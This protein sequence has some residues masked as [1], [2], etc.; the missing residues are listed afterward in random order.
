MKQVQIRKYGS[1]EALEL[2][3]VNAPQPGPGEVL[4]NVEAIG[5]NYSDIL[6]RRNEY[7]LPT[8]LPYVLGTE[9][10]GEVVALGEGGKRTGRGG[11]RARA[12]GAAKRWRLR[13]V[14]RRSRALLHSAAAQHRFG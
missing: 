5:V 12:G 11:W 1:A 13:G 14:R 9:A 3:K 7:F 2:V 4:V 10:V 6:R 8:P